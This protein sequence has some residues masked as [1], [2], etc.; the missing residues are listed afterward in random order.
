[1]LAHRTLAARSVEVPTQA[2]LSLND[3]I[4][5]FE[6]PSDDPL[7]DVLPRQREIHAAAPCLAQ[8]HMVLAVDMRLRLE[9]ILVPFGLLQYDAH[10]LAQEAFLHP[11]GDLFF[12]RAQLLGRKDPFF[13]RSSIGA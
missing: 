8:V 5:R 9:R 6:V 12:P 11:I 1:M 10:S 13:K 3:Q 2:V 4:G 7:G